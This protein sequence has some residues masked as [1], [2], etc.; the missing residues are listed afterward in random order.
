MTFSARNTPT[1]A[2]HNWF[3][4]QTRLEVPV[5]LSPNPANPQAKPEFALQ[6]VFED[7]LKRELQH[8]P[9]YEDAYV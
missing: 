1:T 6:R 5:Y 4:A 8:G 7:T 9:P 3:E 2:I